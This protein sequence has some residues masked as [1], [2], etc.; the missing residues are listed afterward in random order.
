MLK[1]VIVETYKI[2]E[3]P[4]TVEIGYQGENL[5]RV[6]LID[7][8]AWLEQFPEGELSLLYKRPDGIA[9][10]LETSVEN[11][12]ISWKPTDY[13]TAVEGYGFLELRICMGEIV[14]KWDLVKIYIRDSIQPTPEEPPKKIEVPN[15]NPLSII[16]GTTT[17]LLFEVLLPND[18]VYELQEGEFLKFTVK[19]DLYSPVISLYKELTMAQFENGEYVLMLTPSDTKDLDFGVYYYD[20][21]L[22]SGASFF[23]VIECSEF[24]VNYN[25]SEVGGHHE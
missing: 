1:K 2:D 5:F 16:R 14:G 12:I 19:K 11:G 20:V 15:P 17:T 21:G 6:L 3:L 13:D 22:Q 4:S 10:E 9:Y 7:A 8:N 23:S 24:I 18:S 25:A